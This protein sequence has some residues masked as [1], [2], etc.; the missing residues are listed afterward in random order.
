MLVEVRLAS[1]LLAGQLGQPEVEHLDEIVLPAANGE[2]DVGRLD[3]AVNQARRVGLG[4]RR[5]DLAQDIAHPRFG[6][7]AVAVHQ[8]VQV[9]ASRYS[10]A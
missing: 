7:R 3:V 10:M 9:D 6:Q 4:Q 2:E 8:L 5:A 1:W